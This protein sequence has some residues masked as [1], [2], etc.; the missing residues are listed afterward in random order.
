MSNKTFPSQLPII[1]QD[2]AGILSNALACE[3]NAFHWA[4]GFSY[5]IIKCKEDEALSHIVPML[6]QGQPFIILASERTVSHWINQAYRY[7]GNKVV[8][9]TISNNQ[10][11]LEVFYHEDGSSR[12]P[13]LLRTDAC[14]WQWHLCDDDKFEEME[15]NYSRI[16]R[17]GDLKDNISKSESI[18]RD[19]NCVILDINALKKSEFPSKFSPSQ[20]GL[21]SEEAAQ[22]MRYAGFSH[23]VE[24]IAIGGY[25]NKDILDIQSINVLAQLIYYAADGIH[26]RKNELHA[27]IQDITKFHI[28]TEE[29]E[30]APFLFVKGNQ[31]G[32]WWITI[33]DLTLPEDLAK[34]QYYAVSQ[35]DYES[36]LYG[37]H[38]E[39][40]L[41]AQIW[42]DYLTQT[43]VP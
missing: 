23:K 15:E 25:E 1:I 6:E 40:L 9:N 14:A 26:H 5:T 11:W 3:L 17:L 10:S 27:T 43:I 39:T 42:F 30:D 29:D 32:C 19:A 34:H 31:S 37:E 24:C 12:F 2:T 4:K 18:L 7:L 36:A 13:N 16:L 8:L 35:E 41:K 38:T 28:E 33:P 21:S 22:L 20:S